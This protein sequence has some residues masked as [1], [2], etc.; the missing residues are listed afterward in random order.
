MN[1]E[2]N[3]CNCPLTGLVCSTDAGEDVPT[4][5]C[6]ICFCDCPLP[7]MIGCSGPEGHV[8]CHECFS[9]YVAGYVEPGGAFFRVP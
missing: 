5:E 4:G 8:T 7:E 2:P 9:N 6:C 3:A 1:Q